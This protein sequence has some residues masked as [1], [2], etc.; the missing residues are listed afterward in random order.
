MQRCMLTVALHCSRSADMICLQPVYSCGPASLHN[1]T[2]RPSARTAAFQDLGTFVGFLSASSALRLV[3]PNLQVLLQVKAHFRPEFVNR[4]DDFVVFEALKLSEIKQIVRLQAKRVEDRLKDKKMRLELTDSAVDYLAV[5]PGFSCVPHVHTLAGCPAQLAFSLLQG[6]LPSSA[7]TYAL[8]SALGIEYV[9][10]VSNEYFSSLQTKGY[11]PVFG[12]RPV[13]RAVQRELETGL[14]K[15]LLRGKFGEDDTGNQASC[16]VISICRLNWPHP[17]P[18]RGMGL[19]FSLKDK[20][21][22]V[23]PPAMAAF[24]VCK[25]ER[26]VCM[27][28]DCGGPGGRHS[29]PPGIPCQESQDRQWRQACPAT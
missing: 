8:V 2:H 5:W 1:D 25:A 10:N 22:A 12:A 19:P 28:S 13:K 7:A 17:A 21:N 26:V 20:V 4:V 3:C 16:S 18:M 11:D 6:I 9:S 29:R 24:P 15:A 14:A 23:R 27:C